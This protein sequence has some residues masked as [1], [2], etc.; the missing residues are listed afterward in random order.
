MIKNKHNNNTM[1]RLTI[2][3]AVIAMVMG[4]NLLHAQ[5][6]YGADSAECIKYL[7]YYSEYYK[8][9][10]YDEA[11][12]NWRKAYSLC[13][14]TARQSIFTDGTTLVRRLITKA[15]ND[16]AYRQALI[17]TLMTLHETR[18]EYYSKYAVTALNNKGTDMINF[19]KSEPETLYKGLNEVIARNQAETKA[20]ILLMD[21]N[22][23]IEMYQSGKLDA[24]EVINTYQRN[25]A[26]IQEAKPGNDAEAEQIKT[27]KS[28]MEG[29]FITSKVAS[30]DNLISLFTPRYEAAPNDLELATNIVKMM[31]STDDCTDN[32]LYLKAVTSMYTN[33]PSAQSAYYLYR[34]NAA[35]DNVEEANR[36]MEEALAFDNIDPIVAA[37]YNLQ[38]AT[39]CVKN[40]MGAKG[41]E[42]AQKAVELDPNNAGKAYYL[43]GTIWGTTS[44]GG[45]EIQR[46]APYWVAVD[47]MQKAKAA[48]ASLTEDCNRLI[49]QYSAYFPQTAE[50][51][52]YDLTNGQSYTVSCNG[53]RATT[54]VRTQK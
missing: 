43:M 2:I 50:A 19:L 49:G 7:S 18:A 26:L 15:S 21:L 36:Y 37:D 17:D 39:F 52:M 41:Y 35:R 1:K 12:P 11:L 14:P 40:G 10:N 6:K 48:D 9:K 3:L 33:E 24:E 45:D 34:L 27:S 20:S 51:F 54:T 46:R 31:S 38:Y 32:D 44:C 47:Y 23:A 5:G 42:S 28:D 4:G 16:P 13:A 30:C 29:L 22:A 25:L 53:M 8:Q